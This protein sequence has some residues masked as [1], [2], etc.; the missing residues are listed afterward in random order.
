LEKIVGAN[1][2]SFISV[3]VAAFGGLGV[4]IAT[5]SINF[6]LMSIERIRNQSA[7]TP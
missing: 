2:K 7:I 6:W 3:I 5:A 4:A 1:G